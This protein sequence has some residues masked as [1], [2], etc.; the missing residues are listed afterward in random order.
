MKK[1][2]VIMASLLAA[3]LAGCPMPANNGAESAG[4]T[5]KH[6]VNLA[7]TSSLRGIFDSQRESIKVQFVLS[8]AS[9]FE[10]S[11]AGALPAGL[12]MN[13]NGLVSGSATA[14]TSDTTANFT[15]KPNVGASKDLTWV[16]KAPTTMKFTRDSTWKVPDGYSTNT[17]ATIQVLIAGGGGGGGTDEGHGGGGGGG[18]VV[19]ANHQVRLGSS[20]AIKIGAGG[21]GGAGV[22]PGNPGATTEFD[23]LR[24]VGGGG[25]DS[26]TKGVTPIGGN[27]GGLRGWL[28]D[29]TGGQGASGTAV[30]GV[31]GTAGRASTNQYN[32]MTITLGGGG[33]SGSIDGVAG[34]GG[35]G[36]RG[37]PGGANT[38][39]GGS[40]GDVFRDQPSGNAGGS[41]VVYIN[42]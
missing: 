22:A 42:Y 14:V 20:I 19:E 21:T 9:T 25:G 36:G 5:D 24:A 15:V 27:P 39:G 32:N 10:I 26:T 12:T 1:T 37:Q 30:T 18:Q 3:F 13:E 17:T 16:V 29:K 23:T 34:S 4:S 28:D 6:S 35:G 2:V 41:G 8:G 33:A 7:S 31:S 11:G 40:G 38:G